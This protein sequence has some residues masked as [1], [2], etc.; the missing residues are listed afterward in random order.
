[1]LIGGV[2]F[3]V[4]PAID[5]QFLQE[6]VEITVDS[7]ETSREEYSKA[8]KAPN[9]C[10][11]GQHFYANGMIKMY[12]TLDKRVVCTPN[13]SSLLAQVEDEANDP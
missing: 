8:K 4:D 13:I 6:A 2:E 9:G 5:T 11:P 12:G 3:D 1:M 7:D 10:Q